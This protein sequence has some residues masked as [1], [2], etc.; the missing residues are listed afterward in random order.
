MAYHPQAPGLVYPQDMS[1]TVA[2]V[3]LQLLCI[4]NEYLNLK[5][6]HFS[7]P[8]NYKEVPSHT[9]M[10]VIPQTFLFLLLV[11]EEVQGSVSHYKNY[12][13][14]GPSS[15]LILHS[16]SIAKVLISMVVYQSFF[17]SFPNLVFKFQSGSKQKSYLFFFS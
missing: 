17:F 12:F 4:I 8:I 7:P 3:A 10:A 6:L 1:L 9:L 11:P 14:F 15:I 5:N 2:M 13:I 16:M